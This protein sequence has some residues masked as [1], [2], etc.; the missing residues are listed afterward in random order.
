MPPK[1]HNLRDFASSM[2]KDEMPEPDIQNMLPSEHIIIHVNAMIEFIE[3]TD[4]KRLKIQNKKK[5]EELI[6][7]KF[8]QLKQRF[9]MLY[10]MILKQGKQFDMNMFM[11]MM[12][13]YDKV[14]NQEDY[15]EI[16][17]TVGHGLAKKFIP[18]KIY[19]DE[20]KRRNEEENK[21]KDNNKDN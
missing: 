13:Q 2:S 16:S 1:K 3:K 8:I 18:K 7:E 6:N 5:W 12:N 17:K 19:Q 11:L 15:Y 14:R 10:D 21:N 4:T 9:P 20:I